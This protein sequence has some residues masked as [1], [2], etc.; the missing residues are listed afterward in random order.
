MDGCTPFL[1][2]KLKYTMKKYILFFS[3]LLFIAA[4][5]ACNDDE[6]IPSII[7]KNEYYTTVNE[8][9]ILKQ[10]AA[11]SYIVEKVESDSLIVFSR[12]T[13]K[14]VLPEVGTMLFIPI[15]EKTP[16]GFLG[17]VKSVE[18]GNS[19]KVFTETLPLEEA[20]ENLSIDTTM[21]IMNGIESVC[22]AEGNMIDYELID[23]TLIEPSTNTVSSTITRAGGYWQGGI[24]NFPF[25]ITDKDTGSENFSHKLTGKIYVELNNFDFS[26]NIVNN[27]VENIDVKADPIFKVIISDEMKIKTSDK[28]E[29]KKLI[30]S[31][32]CTPIRIPTP[33]G[34]PIILRPKLYMYLVY[35]VS[36]EIVTSLSLQYQSSFKTEMH[37]R[38]EQ[39]DKLFSYNGPENEKPWTVSNIEIKGELYGGTEMGILIGLYS[40]TTGIGINVTPKFALEAN[41]S[42][43]T[44]NL[45]ELNPQVEVAAKWSGDLYFTASIFKRPIAHY[46]FSSPEYV[47]WSEK[48]YLLPCY[49]S[50]E[51]ARN[52]DK[53]SIYYK[54]GERYFLG[55]NNFVTYG[56][57]IFDDDNNEIKSVISSQNVQPDKEGNRYYNEVVDE[58]ELGKIY[59]ASPLVSWMGY[60]WYGDKKL[61]GKG[62][63]GKW[64]REDCTCNPPCHYLFNADGTGHY[65]ETESEG[66]TYVATFKW[67]FDGTYLKCTMD[68]KD[69]DDD[70]IVISKIAF[71][72]EDRFAR[73]DSD[74]DFEPI[75]MNTTY[76]NRAKE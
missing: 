41:A 22:D 60:K 4:F 46:T 42:L 33:V 18:E 50:F 29:K 44:E 62:L 17:K 8:I 15:S 26:L 28:W 11:V 69:P 37:Y 19:I 5:Q 43:S 9:N 23:S 24:I 51:T 56:C 65:S 1:L 68:K 64:I 47:M 36:G 27:K 75:E 30:G 55:W 34:I 16:Y 25:V 73:Y 7:E 72:G 76:F 52:E 63:L 35:G 53:G 48:M 67:N 6:E 31:I 32:N 12:N 2:C 21:N 3:A 71:D 61:I 10:E 57:A 74:F 54:V 45:L 13:P 40:A 66:N 58:L 14:E 20:F 49:T 70:G 59:Y 38:N 39:W